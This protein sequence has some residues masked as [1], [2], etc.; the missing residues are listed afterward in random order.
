MKRRY[1][2]KIKTSLINKFM[3]ENNINK[4]EFCKLSKISHSALNKI[5]NNDF[6]FDIV[7][8][9]RVCKTIKVELRDIFEE[10]EVKK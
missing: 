4:R 7:Y 3:R 9:F 6:D 5:Y 2:C 1:N 8:L 10:I